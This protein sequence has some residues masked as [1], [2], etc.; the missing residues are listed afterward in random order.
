[1]NLISAGNLMMSNIRIT[2][3]AIQRDDPKILFQTGFFTSPHTGGQSHAY[4]VSSDGQRFL[5]LQIDN[6]VA[7]FTGRGR[8]LGINHAQYH[9]RSF[10]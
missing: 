8:G 4:A 2:G 6:P 1:M 5:I 10:C 9:G 7:I 3:S